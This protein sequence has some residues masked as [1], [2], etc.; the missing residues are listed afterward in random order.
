MKEVIPCI[1]TSDPSHGDSV[2]SG[3]PVLKVYNTLDGV[4][5]TAVCP[6]CFR[7]GRKDYAT[8]ETALKHWNEMQEQIRKDRNGWA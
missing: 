2:F 7:G 6:K 5:C 3:M 4:R 1:C 8:A